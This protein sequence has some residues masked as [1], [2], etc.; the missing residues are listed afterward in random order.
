M[1]RFLPLSLPLRACAAAIVALTAASSA[2][3]GFQVYNSEAAFLA[4]VGATRTENFNRFAQDI[5]IA[6]NHPAASGN[7]GGDFVLQGS[8]MID[9][10]TLLRDIDGTTNLFFGLPGGSW[11]DMSFNTPLRAFG[12]WFNGVPPNFTVD[13]N[14]LEG[15]GSYRNVARLQP[16]GSGLQFIGFT[17]D[18]TFNRLVFES[19]GCCSASFAIDNLSYA[20][21]LAPVP[22]PGS[23]ALMAAGLAGIGAWNRRR[24]QAPRSR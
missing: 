24:Q 11:A 1:P 9:S 23:W 16:S 7:F 19:N 14:S 10:P 5:S 22:E 15:L 8:W 3:A 17:S 6:S 21:A 13:A 18:Q 2:H 4:A 12:A 20:A